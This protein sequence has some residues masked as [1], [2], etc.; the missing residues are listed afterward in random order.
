MIPTRRNITDLNAY[1]PG[2]Q[3]VDAAMVK[4]NTNENPYPPSPK[5]IEAIRAVDPESL[6]KYPPADAPAFR[7]LAAETHDLEPRQVIATNGGDELLRLAITTF[8]EPAGSDN[9]SPRGIVVSRPTYALYRVLA[10]IQDTPVFEIP[11]TESLEWPTDFID[12]AVHSGAGL[13]MIVNPHAPSGRMRPSGDFRLLAERF[14]GVLLIDEAYVDFADSNALDLIRRPGGLENVLILRSLSKGYG[15]AGLRFGYG[16]GGVE[17]IAAMHK[18]R[19]SYNVD[20]IAQRAAAAALADQPYAR[21]TWRKVR[22]ERQRISRE[23]ESRGIPVQPSQSNFILASLPSEV[24]ARAM[25]ERL[26]QDHILVRYF[27]EDRLRDKL[28]ITIGTPEQNQAL[29]A[30]F[31]AGDWKGTAL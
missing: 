28:R 21:E 26:R 20:F 25:L 1:V 15:L 8:C 30:A 16:L 10:E 13:A 9:R 22:E 17:L 2:E 24:A 29:L 11:L 27:D 12:Q 4:L 14:P 3:P 18:A 23:L 6:R 5:V 31:D 7:A 19:D